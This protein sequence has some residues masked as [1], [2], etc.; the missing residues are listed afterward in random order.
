MPGTCAASPP[1]HNTALDCDLRGKEEKEEEGVEREGYE[2]EK[3]NEYL[4][5]PSSDS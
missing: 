5:K 4:L 2:K 3:V 1:D